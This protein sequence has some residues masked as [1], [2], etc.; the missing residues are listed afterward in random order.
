MYKVLKDFKGSPDGYTVI[1]YHE[2]EV[3]PLPR[4]L[5][6]V[7][8]AEKWVE[9][10]AVDAAPEGDAAPAPEGD[11]QAAPPKPTRGSRSR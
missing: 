2:G 9:E 4:S 10:V 3:V 8:I 7:A 5:A 1:E 11:A 6:E